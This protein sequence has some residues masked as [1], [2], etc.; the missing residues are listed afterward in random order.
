MPEDNLLNPWSS[1]VPA[2]SFVRPT[3]VKVPARFD[4]ATHEGPLPMQFPPPS[5]ADYLLKLKEAA[6]GEPEKVLSGETSQVSTPFGDVT[7]PSGAGD[8]ALAALPLLGAPEEGARPFFS[9]LAKTIEERAPASGVAE[10]FLNVAR[11]G[12]KAEELQWSGLEE[13]LRERAGQKVTKQEV[14]DHLSTNAPDLHERMLSSRNANAT[15]RLGMDDTNNIRPKFTQYTLPGGENQRELVVTMP[16][17][18]STSMPVGVAPEDPLDFEEWLRE[19]QGGSL[20]DFENGSMGEQSDIESDYDRYLEH[21]EAEHPIDE[22]G[23]SDG[24]NYHVPAEHT[25]GDPELDTNRLMHMRF[26][27][28]TTGD[29][30]KALHLEELQS[31]WHQAG[32]KEGYGVQNTGFPSRHELRR[33]VDDSDVEDTAALIGAPADYTQN[34]A[35]WC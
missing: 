28:R 35:T 12:S 23:L 26:N 17:K 29:G 13:Y 15:D 25:Y 9:Q 14:L 10:H 3:N 8:A 20:D 33:F 19:E 21:H 2:I 32:R 18:K 31:D 5:I 16:Q 6:F 34:L 11:K 4:P 27:D 30:E 22:K 1:H 24:V 7:Y